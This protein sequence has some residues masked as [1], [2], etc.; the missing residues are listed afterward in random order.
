MIAPHDTAV[1]DKAPDAKSTRFLHV[2]NGDSVRVTMEKSS[3]P[4]TLLVWADV[5][6]EGPVPYDVDDDRWNE[7]RGHFLT[8]REYA[9]HDATSERLNDWTSG[10]RRYAEFD[11]VVLWFEHDLFDQLLLIHHLD[12]F[13]RRD[14]GDTTLSL[15]CIGEY[16]GFER[17]DGLGQLDAD[18][19]ASL[20]GTRQRVTARQ[21][22]LA[23]ATW[24]AFTSDDPTNIERV[25]ARDTSALPFLDGAMRRM[26]EEYPSTDQGLSGTARHILEIL[27][28][29]GTLTT[30]DLFRAEQGKEERVFMG[31][32]SFW[33]YVQELASGPSPAVAVET[34]ASDPRFPKGTVSITETGRRVLAGEVDWVK[35]AGL[36]RWIGGVHLE[37]RRVPWRWDQRAGKLVVE[38]A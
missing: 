12:W 29:R 1:F 3:I 27:A 9:A 18:Q 5:L 34:E 20:L 32:W 30:A 33:K 4:G 36:D 14:L 8:G 21:T 23:R 10:L 37:G 17:F 22:E 35:L 7:T 31:D 26:L 11:E 24:R 28:E 19:L 15:I 13:G 25:L 38:P 6:H 16:P 2:L